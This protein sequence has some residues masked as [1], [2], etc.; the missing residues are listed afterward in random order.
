MSSDVLRVELERVARALG[1]G[2][3]EFVLE[4]PRD[5][6]HGD[7]ATNLA[8]VLA[9]RRRRTRARWPKRSCAELQLAGQRSIAKTEIAGPGF[10]NFWLAEDTARR[11]CTRASSPRARATGGATVGRGAQGQRRVRLG[12][13]DR[14]AA[15]GPRPRRGAGRRDR[16]A[17]R[18]DRARGHPRVLHQRRRRADRPAGPEPLGPG[19]AGGGPRRGDSRGRLPRRV[20][21]GERGAGARSGRARAFAD[22]PYEEGVR[23]LPGARRSR[24]SA[25]SRTATSPTSACAST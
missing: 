4:R 7:L 12:Q 10:I 23:A 20:P 11:R 19:A 14:P 24:S 17:A 5:D 13:P 9:K 16:V 15:R 2:D 21:A 25:R 3:V 18:V 6:T 22:L 1:A 8:L